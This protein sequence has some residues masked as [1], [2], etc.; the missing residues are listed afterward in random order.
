MIYIKQ[1]VEGDIYPYEPDWL[2]NDLRA[3]NVSLV[4]THNTQAEADAFIETLAVYGVHPVT[5][6]QKPSGDVVTEG[7][8]IKVDGNYTQQWE[9]RDYGPDDLAL[10]KRDKKIE[11]KS[12]F[13]EKSERPVIDTGMGFSVSAGYNDLIDFQVGAELGILGVR[14]YDNNTYPVT[15]EQMSGIITMIKQNGLLLK[16]A[17]WAKEDA[18]DAIT[19]GEGETYGDAIDAVNSIDLNAGW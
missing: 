18:I 9:A 3:L 19:P 14:A 11:L 10:M 2:R 1:A 8:P 12:L 6:T 16:Q 15:A 5:P 4:T 7:Q 17:K 13:L